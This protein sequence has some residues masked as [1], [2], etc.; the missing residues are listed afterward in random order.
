MSVH[1]K[2]KQKPKPPANCTAV[3]G[4]CIEDHLPFLR[5][6][7]EFLVC[8]ITEME[9]VEEEF[10]GPAAR[11]A[12]FLAEKSGDPEAVFQA[13][14]RILEK[15]EGNEFERVAAYALSKPNAQSYFNASDFLQKGL[16]AAALLSFQH[17]ALWSL[18]NETYHDKYP[19]SSDEILEAL[20]KTELRD[21][22]I[23]CQAVCAQLG[24]LRKQFDATSVDDKEELVRVSNEFCQVLL[25]VKIKFPAFNLP[26]TAPAPVQA[27]RAASVQAAEAPVPTVQERFPELTPLIQTMGNKARALSLAA[28]IHAGAESLSSLGKFGPMRLLLRLATAI[29]RRYLGD[30]DGSVARTLVQL[31]GSF[32]LEAKRK[33]DEPRFD[34]IL[35]CY[36]EAISILEAQPEERKGLKPGWPALGHVYALY[37]D[38][39][40]RMQEDPA[41]ALIMCYNA[42]NYFESRG[43]LKNSEYTETLRTHLDL[44]IPFDARNHE[45]AKVEQKLRQQELKRR[46]C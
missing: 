2:S 10:D 11:L 23:S 18:E 44:I 3:L 28:A 46:A 45:A 37:A 17:G 22:V 30:T 36:K 40:N 31:A 34:I 20:Q 39:L 29:N 26:C 7:A 14:H 32:E 38:A 33:D 41:E 24:A 13:A 35:D 21:D 9:G 16:P 25:R 15:C 6:H 4:G 8:K 27:E 1:S 42:E 5:K 43:L 12:L 19:Y